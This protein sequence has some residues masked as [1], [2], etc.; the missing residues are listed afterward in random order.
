L[1]YL[2]DGGLLGGNFSPPAKPESFED[3]GPAVAAENPDDDD[4]GEYDALL[5]FSC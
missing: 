4:D 1:K 5:L 2:D 3:K